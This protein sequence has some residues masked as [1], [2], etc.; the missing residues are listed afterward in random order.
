M[1]KPVC[2]LLLTAEA[3]C[4]EGE[5]RLVGSNLRSE[6]RVELCKYGRWGTVCADEAWDDTDAATVCRQLNLS[7]NILYTTVQ[8]MY[9]HTCSS[10][11]LYMYLHAYTV[12]A[13]LVSQSLACISMTCLGKYY[14][15]CV[16]CTAIAIAT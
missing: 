5:L 15:P 1:I 3:E 7:G 14:T 12:L 4:T 9:I 6:G 2:I 16:M 11:T 13:L 10:A 8:C